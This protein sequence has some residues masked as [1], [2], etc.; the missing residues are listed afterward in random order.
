M[1]EAQEGDADDYSEE[2]KPFDLTGMQAGDDMGELEGEDVDEI[3]DPLAGLRGAEEEPY[4]LTGAETT[5]PSDPRGSREQDA[6]YSEIDDAETEQSSPSAS[7]SSAPATPAPDPGAGATTLFER[8]ANLSRSSASEDEDD[9]E[10]DEDTTAL[11]IPRFL[12]RQNNQ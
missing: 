8:M 4:D 1:S 7:G 3:V 2:A 6:V 9:D 11:S 10:G 5:E 12:G